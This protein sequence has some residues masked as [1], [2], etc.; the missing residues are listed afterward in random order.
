MRALTALTE[1]LDRMVELVSLPEREA[2]LESAG[3]HFIYHDAERRYAEFAP[4]DTEEHTPILSIRS[5]YSL[6]DWTLKMDRFYDSATVDGLVVISARGDSVAV[7]PMWTPDRTRAEQ[8]IKPFYA[9]FTP[10]PGRLYTPKEVVF[11][12]ETLGERVEKSKAIRDGF[13][14]RLK[15]VSGAP[16]GI[17]I[18]APFGDPNHVCKLSFLVEGTDTEEGP[19]FSFALVND[20]E[21][22]TS[23]VDWFRKE[24]AGDAGITDRWLVVDAP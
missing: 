13:K 18:T 17:R 19:R 14:N 4:I 24:L 12:L 20:H 21:A 2:K 9:P 11:W 5:V 6:I 1:A 16:T 8:A 3:R 7:T 23:Y 15:S 10:E 22:T